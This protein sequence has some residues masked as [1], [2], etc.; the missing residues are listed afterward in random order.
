[1]IVYDGIKTEFL[2]SV[3]NG[4]IAEEVRQ[5]IHEKMGRTTPKSEFDSWKNS[6]TR[7]YLV[8]SDASIPDHAGIA[9]E[10]NVPQTSKRVDFIISGYDEYNQSN[11][12]IIELKQWDEVKKVDGKDALVETYTGGGLREIVHPPISGMVICYAH[13]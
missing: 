8:L 4:T 5:R 10:Y 6:L 11:A 7:M 12:V 1:M 9:I 3:M 13:T 2:N